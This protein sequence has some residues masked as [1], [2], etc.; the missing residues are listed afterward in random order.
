MPFLVDY[1]SYCQFT[2]Q[3]YMYRSIDGEN[4]NTDIAGH[5]LEM[6]GMMLIS[7]ISSFFV[8]LKKQNVLIKDWKTNGQK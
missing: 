6:A 7:T 8:I 1:L 5:M 4:R 2:E 3:W